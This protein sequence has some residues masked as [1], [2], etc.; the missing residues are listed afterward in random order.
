ME[1]LWCSVK[2]DIRELGFGRYAPIALTPCLKEKCDLW[3]AGRWECI[4]IRKAGKP[5][6]FHRTG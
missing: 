6:V 3:K 1:T 5:E 4:H 2:N